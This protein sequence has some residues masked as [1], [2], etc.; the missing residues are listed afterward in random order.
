LS[1][2]V[3][4]CGREEL[5]LRALGKMTSSL[6][7]KLG[8]SLSSIKKFDAPIEEATTSSLEALKSFSVG[9][10]FY[11][12]GKTAEAVTHLKHAVDLDGN[13]ALAYY[14][15]GIA[16]RQ[17]TL[18]EE[19][20]RKAF[21]LRDRVTEREKLLISSAY[22]LGI[23][24]EIEKSIEALE[25]VKQTYP[26]DLAAHILLGFRNSD[27]GQ[28]E[29]AIAEHSEA[30][31]INPNIANQ[32]G[33]LAA[34]FIRLDRYDEAVEI[35]ERAM[36]LKLDLAR[37]HETLYSIAFIRGDQVGMA[38]Q[39]AWGSR[40]PDEF[41]HFVW[42]GASASFGGQWR[43]AEALSAQ[44]YEA[45]LRLNL[46]EVAASLDSD[47]AMV[48]ALFGDCGTVRAGASRHLATPL[49]LT[50]LSKWGKALAM[51]SEAGQAESVADEMGKRFP[52]DSF[53]QSVFLPSIRALL[54]INRNNPSRAI[55]LLQG[56]S[57][58]EAGQSIYLW[59]AYLRG[60]AYLRQ[61]AGDKAAAEFRK[62]LDHRGQV[63][64]NPLF[65][66]SHLG[67]AR[68]AALK[69]E[70]ATSRHEY[71]DFLALWK[72]ADTDLPVLVEA[73]REY[74]KLK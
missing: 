71:Q 42:Q 31:R 53:A 70:T 19:A 60:L 58:Y 41:V 54:E 23:T 33:G 40:T 56:A 3:L 36:Q 64:M 38:E 13:F 29:K 49:T 8:E 20:L 52:K 65:P 48:G 21:E 45:A 50:S 26:R 39:V 10:E 55:E 1:R 11:R 57:R 35:C 24:G 67:L 51:C 18:S 59:P 14:V 7:K 28:Y 22:Y 6:R 61:G 2:R 44:A 25:L 74:Q 12:Q 46:E 15:L 69:G 17:S 5:V 66:L 43:K 16:Y 63:A 32:Y 47:R 9:R 72:D 4:R 73:K 27:I 37:Y 62:I 30:I 68:A 34:A